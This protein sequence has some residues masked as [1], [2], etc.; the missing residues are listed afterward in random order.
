MTV[1]GD[2]VVARGRTA[3]VFADEPGRVRRR[4]R[5]ARDCQA[6]AAV[7]EHARTH[8]FPVPRVFDVSGS[9]IV[10]ERVIG[11][12]MLADLARRPWQLRS[13]A[14]LLARLHGQLHAITAPA[15]LQSPFHDGR[16]LLHLDLHPENIIVGASGPWV[17][18][19]TNAAAGP[20]SADVAQTWV[21]IASSLVPGPT[22]QRVAGNL[23]RDLFLRSFLR[24]FDRSDLCAYLPAVARMRLTDEN[25][26]ELERRVIARMLEDATST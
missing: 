2:R 7:M 3:D 11:R 10:M 13:H 23:G 19:W 5:A 6:E 15:W 12:S 14:Q 1:N 8:G 17:I 18:D 16:A 20:P 24:H 26:Q 9:D 4:Y 25:L 22:W 21:L